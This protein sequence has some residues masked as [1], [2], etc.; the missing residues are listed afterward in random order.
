MQGETMKQEADA[1][2]PDR[3]GALKAKVDALA[4]LT[5]DLEDARSSAKRTRFGIVV[6]ILLVLLIFGLSFF[7][8]YK[9]FDK[10]DF[11]AQVQTKLLQPDAQTIDL[12]QTSA[13][14]V[15]PVYMA[16]AQKQFGEV[17]PELQKQ[18][19]TEGQKYLE[20]IGAKVEE[21][22]KAK[23]DAMALKQQ[24]KLLAEFPTLKDEKTRDIIMENLEKALQG[25]VVDV[26]DERVTKAEAR[27]WE[28]YDQMIKF[29]PEESQGDFQARMAKAWDQFLMVKLVTPDMMK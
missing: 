16:E 8:M 14:E 13:R 24:E 22:I 18:L 25:A 9:D 11:V 17:W 21:H 7:K 19:Q 20:N 29:L 26:L 1:R 4:K 10:K 12:L 15:L 5:Q 28:V 27:I 23:V 3:V 2:G 6:G